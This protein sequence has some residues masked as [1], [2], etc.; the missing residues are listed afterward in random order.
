M[1]VQLFN[2][3]NGAMRKIW[4]GFGYAMELGESIEGIVG[5]AMW[6][7]LCSWFSKIFHEF[8]DEKYW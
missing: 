6:W 3:W 1:M 5:E 7:D 8:K 4:C 2:A